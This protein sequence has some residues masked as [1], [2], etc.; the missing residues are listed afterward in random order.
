M[1]RSETTVI[2]GIGSNLGDREAHIQQALDALRSVASSPLVKSRVYETEPV[3]PGPQGKYLNLC[4]RFATRL[5]ARELLE[6][7]R[8]TEIRLGRQPRGKWAPREIDLDILAYGGDIIHEE[9]FIIPHP[10][11]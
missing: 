2:L 10:H 5:P 9:G 7:C 11:I 6:W 4:V 1:A 8:E 3:G